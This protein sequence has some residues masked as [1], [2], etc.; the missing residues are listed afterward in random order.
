MPRLLN[1][2][3]KSSQGDSHY[4]WKMHPLETKIEG[5]GIGRKTILLNISTIA[6]QCR[7][8]PQY[9]TKFFG[10]EIGAQTRYDKGR[11]VGIVNGV[12]ET[13]DLQESIFDY[14]KVIIMCPSAACMMPS[15]R[16]FEKGKNIQCECRSCG[17][18]QSINIHRHPVLKYMKNNFVQFVEPKE[19]GETTKKVKHSRRRRRKAEAKPTAEPVELKE[20]EIAQVSIEA[21]IVDNPVEALRPLLEVKKLNEFTKLFEGIQMGHEFEADKMCIIFS[22]VILDST[23]ADALMKSIDKYSGFLRW[24]T[25]DANQREIFMDHFLDLVIDLDYTGN[26]AHLFAKFHEKI[27]FHTD[28]FQAWFEK[29]GK[30]EAHEELREYA[31]PFLEYIREGVYETFEEYYKE[32]YDTVECPEWW[33]NAD[34]D[35]KFDVKCCLEGEDEFE[36]SLVK[37]LEDE[38]E[39][40]TE[41][42]K[43]FL[44]WWYNGGG[45]DEEDY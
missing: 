19:E 7:T 25:A 35:M 12:H 21:V 41:D 6:V 32:N 44:D 45:Q 3:L 5:S 22:E 17:L 34:E 9:M 18:N 43:I 37:T 29:N 16:Y 42:A 26:L 13:K 1:V 30:D 24:Y 10:Y 33:T 11:N 4:R 31:D 36:E 23:S 14:I 2:G 28:F 38:C 8:Q 15:I 27:I 40:K 39:V 20:E